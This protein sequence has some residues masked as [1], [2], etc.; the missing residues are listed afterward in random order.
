MS[1]TAIAAS[2]PSVERHWH[3]ADLHP[4]SIDTLWIFTIPSSARCGHS[5]FLR[6]QAVDIRCSYWSNPCLGE[7]RAFLSR[8]F[9]QIRALDLGCCD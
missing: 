8:P 9:I 3:V 1:I 2:M 7:L 4:S 5:P 6:P